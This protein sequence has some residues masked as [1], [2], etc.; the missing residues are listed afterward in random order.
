MK[1]SD[2]KTYFVGALITSG[3]AAILLFAT[4]FAGFDGSNYY[5]GVYYWG[6][7][8]AFSGLSGV[9]IIISGFLLLYC[10]II[11]VLILKAPDKI[12]DR[13]FVKYGFF[14]A[15]IALILLIIGGIVFA[16]VAYEEDWWWWF[17][18]GFYGGVIGGLLTA[19]LFYLGEKTVEL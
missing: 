5:L 15:V 11:S 2:E 13:K 12:P 4:N 14:A 9:P 3:V 1:M 18:A 19:I 7:I 8:G 17:D 6:G 10:M 16:A